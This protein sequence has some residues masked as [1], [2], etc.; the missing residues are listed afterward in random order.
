MT[1]DIVGH[2]NLGDAFL[3]AADARPER[4][5]LTVVHGAEADPKEALTFAELADR[6]RARAAVLADR[7]PPGERV[8]MALPTGTDFVQTYVSCLLAGLVVVPAPAPGGSAIAVARLAAIAD[9][10]APG[11]VVTTA[12]DRTVVAEQ[13]AGRA[14]AVCAPGELAPGPGA[15]SRPDPDRPV[16]G[17]DA[18]AIIQY[19]SGSTAAP[20]G[21]MLSHGDVLSNLQAMQG[22]TTLG[23]Q[24][25]FGS[26]LP[27]YHDFGLF[28]QFTAALLYGASTVLMQPSEFVRRPASW[29]RMMSRYRVTATSAPNFSFDLCLRL[30]SDEQLDGVDLSPLRFLCNG[31]EP[32]NAAAMTTFTKRFAAF[33]LRPEAMT[34]GY[35]MAETTVY[36]SCVPLDRE[37]P[38]L[39]AD[40]AALESGSR[41]ELRPAG[42][43]GRE[44]VA[45][46][47]ARGFRLRVVDRDTRAV[48]PDGAIGEVWLNGP[49]I[50][51][52]Y[53]ERP[54]L[55]EATFGGRL[56]AADDPSDLERVWLRTGDLGALVDGDLYVTG[57]TK[58]V[59]IVRGRNLFP[60]DI[61]QQA[62]AAHPA[63]VGFVG[64]AFGVSDP[65]ERVVL[66]HE[67]SPG[68]RA[69]ELRVVAAAVEKHL[70]TV[71]G[72]AVGNVVLVRR[73]TVPRTTSG[74]I[75]RVA[76][77]ERFLA[78]GVTPLHAVRP[79]PAAPPDGAR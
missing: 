26:W 75:Q 64:A 3:A 48:L 63:L 57:R 12:E 43:P 34:P 67:V 71:F 37:P 61:E 32:I 36:V 77:R 19:S 13:L 46:G 78:G 49:G 73:G 66:V 52:G 50:G 8:L 79:V 47:G 42:G 59:M 14:A 9:D 44:I 53:W 16:P 1:V 38:V 7:L 74:K 76:M 40:V 51:R 11:L 69:E 22:A 33:G 20:R 45:L 55:T 70:A 17:H 35:G 65:D 10:C 24:D 31:S 18:L 28:V 68:T 41:P 30:I 2:R 60:H 25:V 6:V 58:E 21:V 54:E 39:V 72:V 56:T 23:P 15:G 62:R 27:L 29:L 4:V 5:A